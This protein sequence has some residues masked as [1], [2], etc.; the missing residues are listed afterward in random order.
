MEHDDIVRTLAGTLT[1][2]P[3]ALCLFGM[4]NVRINALLSK[5]DT[6]L[7]RDL[8]MRYPSL[9]NLKNRVPSL[10]WRRLYAKMA[11]PVEANPFDA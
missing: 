10:T 8:A 2:C 6:P 4:V 7:W 9:A 5:M 3:D 11:R 1:E